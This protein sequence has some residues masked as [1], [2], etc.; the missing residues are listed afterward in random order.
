MYFN[1]RKLI[2]VTFMYDWTQGNLPSIFNDPWT[3]SNN[4]HSCATSTSYNLSVL[5]CCLNTSQRGICSFVLI[6][7][8][9]I[10]I[11]AITTQSKC[12]TLNSI[13]SIPNLGTYILHLLFWWVMGE[14]ASGIYVGMFL[15]IVCFFF[16]SFHFNGIYSILS[17]FFSG[18]ATNEFE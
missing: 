9:G 16:F 6:L 3:L 7:N 18:S 11:T 2:P 14:G 12:N 4:N 15:S 8:K 5:F 10:T 13:C 17:L 1:S